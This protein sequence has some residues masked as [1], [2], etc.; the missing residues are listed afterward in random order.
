MRYLVLTGKFGMGHVVAAEAVKQELQRKDDRNQIDVVDILE[1]FWPFLGPK[2]YQLY[3]ALIGKCITLYNVFY[4]CSDRLENMGLPAKK[5][6]AEKVQHMLETYQP[7]SVISTH[8]LSSKILSIYKEETGA[9]I[10]LCTCVTDMH[11]HPDWICKHTD[12]YFVPTAETKEEMVRRGVEEQI[13]SPTGMLVRTKFQK[14]G[15]ADRI[16]QQGRKHV[17]VMGGGIGLLPRRDQLLHALQTLP[18]VDVTV[19]AGKNKKLYRRLKNQYKEMNVLYYTD[20]IEAYMQAADLIVTKPGGI[21][22]FEA[23]N[24]G[25]PLFV[26]APFMGQE[27]FNARYIKEHNLG[28]V[29]DWKGADY[30]Q[31]LMNCLDQDARLAQMR[32]NMSEICQGWPRD[33]MTQVVAGLAG[34]EQ[35]Q[36]S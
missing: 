33:R 31:E 6:L 35:V 8:P 4:Y 22:L 5:R 28:V 34:G 2:A 1:E 27:A 7:D 14:G 21:T 18:N 13:I 3:N 17:L 12:M 36:C 19:I 23:V 32:R 30:K 24:L 29:I 11:T 26:V 25:V 20:R 9:Q 10:P 16:G 15:Q